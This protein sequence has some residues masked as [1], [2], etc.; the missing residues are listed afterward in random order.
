V[1][2]C[3]LAASTTSPINTPTLACTATPAI[4]STESTSF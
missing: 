1:M 4:R 3:T 2:L